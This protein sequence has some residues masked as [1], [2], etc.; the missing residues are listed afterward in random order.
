MDDLWADC[1]NRARRPN[2]N[3]S[4]TIVMPFTDF[5]PSRSAF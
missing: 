3:S 4:T 5:Y 2:A 1:A